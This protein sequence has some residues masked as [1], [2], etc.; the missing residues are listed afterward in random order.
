MEIKHK[1][2]LFFLIKLFCAFYKTVMIQGNV[3][4]CFCSFACLFIQ[5]LHSASW[6]WLNIFRITRIG[7]REITD[8]IFRYVT[9]LCIGCKTYFLMQLRCRLRLLHPRSLHLEKN[10]GGRSLQESAWESWVIGWKE[11]L[12]WRAVGR[13]RD[14]QQQENGNK[15]LYEWEEASEMILW[16][17]GWDEKENGHGI[18]CVS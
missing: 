11:K 16:L 17:G 8:I 2:H 14:E 12:G 1:E 18:S 6:F 10:L 3:I 9:M 13:L 5:M 4:G 7:P 15:R